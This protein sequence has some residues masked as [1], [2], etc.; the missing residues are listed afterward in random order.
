MSWLNRPVC[1][2]GDEAVLL[3]GVCGGSGGG[4]AGCVG[5]GW[6][7]GGGERDDMYGGDAIVVAF[8][9]MRKGV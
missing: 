9:E 1:E 4:Y 6:C 3:P 7:S 2:Y 8:R 5:L